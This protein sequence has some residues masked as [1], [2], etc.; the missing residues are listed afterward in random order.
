[1]ML[2]AFGMGT[3]IG[4]HMADPLLAMAQGIMLA[5]TSLALIGSLAVRKIPLPQAAHAAQTATA[6]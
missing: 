1:M 2:V 5:A 6:K 3:W 4:T